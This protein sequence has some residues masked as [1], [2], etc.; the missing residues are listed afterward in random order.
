[1]AKF[2][3]L[4]DLD[5]T[6]RRVLVR[7]DYNVPMRDGRVTDATRIERSL[8]TIRDLTGRGARVI[9]LSHF[10]RPKG[11]RVAEMSLRPAAASLQAVLEGGA[12]FFADDCIGAVAETAVA[13]L[14]QGGVLLLENLRFHGGEEANDADFAAALA[15]LGDLY[16]DDAFSAAHRAHAS[17]EALARRLPAA[18]GRLMQAELEHLTAALDSPRH[19]VA[20]VVGGAKV[21]SKLDLLGNLVRKVD[22]LIIGG[23]M[24]NTFLHAQGTE[25]G[26]SLCEHD[27]APTARAILKTAADAGCEIYLPRDAVVAEALQVGAATKTV[28]IGDVPSVQMIL[29][30]GP[31][32]AKDIAGRLAECRTLVWNGPLGCFEVPPFDAGTN[33]VAQEAARLTRAGGLLSVAGGGDT[34]AALSHAGAINDFSYVSAAGGAFL[35]WLEGKTLPGIAALEASAAL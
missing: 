9:L 31:A 29:D 23:G 33:A 18:A 34:V 1:M 14:P 22:L 3:T 27:L 7:V 2:K 10:G 24:A 12:V 4:D 13:A 5:V 26:R 16:V 25:I 6:G 17:V 20:A 11:K 28:S 30:I 21:S 19:P 35:E 15:R 32:T 8:P